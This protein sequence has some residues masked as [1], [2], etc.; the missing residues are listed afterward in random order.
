MPARLIDL[1]THSTASDGSASPSALLVMAKTMGLSALA[2]TDH[3]TVAGIAEAATAAHRHGISFVPGVEIS[4]EHDPGTMH[5]LGLFINAECD[6]LTHVLRKYQQ[7]RAERNSAMVAKLNQLGIQ[8]TMAEWQKRASGT[9]GRP[10][11]AGLLIEKG[12]VQGKQEAFAKYLAKGAAA[13]IDRLRLAPRAAIDAIHA[14]GGLAVLAHP[15]QLKYENHA[16]C[17]RIVRGLS[18]LGLDGIEAYHSDHNAQETRYFLDLARKHSLLPSGGSDFH[19]NVKPTIALGSGAG[20]NC[21]VPYEVFERL[22]DAAKKKS[23]E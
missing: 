15:V 3:D 23:R 20:R 22:R 13:Y 2:L 11:L 17:E 19:G 1:H 14:A 12:Y 21:R 7:G 4:A 18:E 16:Q 10:H 9:V 5:I 6:T 8:V